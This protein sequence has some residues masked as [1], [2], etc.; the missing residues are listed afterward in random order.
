MKKLVIVLFVVISQAGWAQNDSLEVVSLIHSNIYYDNKN[1]R[2]V[3]ITEDDMASEVAI[4]SKYGLE[5]LKGQIAGTA[6]GLFFDF[7]LEELDGKLMYGFIPLGDSKHPHPVYFRSSADVRQGKVAINIKQVLSKRYDM[8]GW[9]K[10]GYGTIGYRIIDTEGKM[11][12]DGVITFKGTGPFE[13]SETIVEGPFVNLL[14]EEGATI[15]FDTNKETAPSITVGGKTF[16]SETGTHHEI[17]IKGL[18]P[19]TDYE[20]TVNYGPHKETYSFHTAPEPGSRNAF[21]FAYASDSRAG[22]GGGERNLHG[23]N[24]YIMKKIM[25]LARYENARFVQFTGDMINGYLTND[26]EMDLQYANWKRAVE[27]FAHYFPIVAGMGNHEAFMRVFRGSTN[28]MIDKYPYDTQSGEAMFARNFVNP[29]NG[30]DSEDGASYD[31]NSSRTDFPSY[32]ENVFFYT[33]DNVAV[34][35]MNSD[36]WYSPSSHTIPVIGGGLHGYIMDNQLKWFRK[37]IKDLEKNDDIDHVFITQH[38]PFFPNGGHVGDDMWYRGN[39]EKRP[40]VAGKPLKKGIIERRDEL[41]DIIVNQSSKVRAIL[42]GDEH[43]Y[44]KTEIGPETNIYPE[45]WD[46]KKLELSRTIYQVN[47]GAA[48][49]PYYAQEQTPWT[50]FT[51]RFTTQNAL[52]FFHV[53]GKDL[54]LEVL[55]PD[56]LEKVDELKLQ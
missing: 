10:N 48:G 20:Y 37:T 51:S 14:N 46:M 6:T 3:I 1:Q 26:Q 32:K 2:Q 24:F 8:V 34:V 28:Y 45:N 50:P 42:T 44:C 35:N 33:Y 18:D 55:N 12:Y 30:P 43:N 40:W 13:V 17:E 23:A 15:S 56:T 41:L 19:N 29:Q 27:P 5:K 53:E 25:A 38:T 31:P 7:G 21:S 52:V 11:L 22:N 9:E 16:K 47:N 36:Y 4:P 54:T 39:N 49:A